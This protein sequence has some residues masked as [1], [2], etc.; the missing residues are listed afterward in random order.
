M[1]KSKLL[2]VTIFILLIVMVAGCGEG[3]DKKEKEK[4]SADY[5]NAEAFEAALNN[6][7]DVEG[8]IVV[9][10]AGEVHPESV[11]G[12]NVWAGEHLNFV[13]DKD[14]GIKEGDT[15][16]VKILTVE[17]TLGSWVLTYEKVKHVEITEDT[18]VD[19]PGEQDDEINGLSDEEEVA[20]EEQDNASANDS[21]D[22]VDSNQ[23]E[24]EPEDTPSNVAS[25][26]DKEDEITY[27]VGDPYYVTFS[28]YGTDFVTAYFPITNTSDVPITKYSASIDFE[29]ADGKLIETE[30]YPEMVPDAI[31][32]GQTGYIYT[33]YHRTN[34][35]IS[36]EVANVVLSAKLVEAE[37][38]YEI[39]VSDVSFSDGSVWVNVIGRGTN[40]GDSDIFGTLPCAIYYGKN[41]EVLGFCYGVESFDSGETK[42]FEISGSMLTYDTKFSD[43][44]HVVVYIQG[45]DWGY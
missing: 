23:L 19:V 35:D 10:E 43:I 39:E 2:L 1:K 41:D 45:D 20:D 44:D 4:I 42:S 30:T 7:D 9:F 18:I 25:K 38:F 6:G 15:V 33:Y 29:D 26:D 13:S 32:P 28:D 16:S 37:N 40:N 31:K 21:G 36:D 17:N 8:A 14:T 5:G 27:E 12:F 34:G 11:L 22:K 3:T 24:K